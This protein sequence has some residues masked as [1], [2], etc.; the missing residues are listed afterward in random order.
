VAALIARRSWEPAF[1]VVLA[2]LRSPLLRLPA[3][4]ALVL[5]EARP[6]VEPHRPVAGVDGHVLEAE[7]PGSAIVAFV[8]ESIHVGEVIAEVDPEE[9][10]IGL[11]VLCLA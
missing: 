4:P 8:R 10:A 1:A 5:R 3:Q 9:A 7:P 6:L 2:F 11:P